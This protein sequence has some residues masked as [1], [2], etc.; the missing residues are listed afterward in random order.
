MNKEYRL[1]APELR[2][3]EDNPSKLVG[4]AATFDFPTEIGGYFTETIAAGAFTETLAADNIVALFNHD[5][6]LVLGRNMAGTLAL[7]EDTRGLYFEIDLPDTQVA[8]DLLVSVQR[9]DISGCSFGFQAVEENWDYDT[10]TRTLLKVKLFDIS[11]VTNPAYT[12][13]S[14]S[15]RSAKE[16]FEEFR[17]KKPAHD[18]VPEQTDIDITPLTQYIEVLRNW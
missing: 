14:V 4:Y 18:V 10:E 2:A 15:A 7:R 9:R 17:S 1:S 11:I 3:A 12:N 6:N 13:T 5:D 8:R 16:V